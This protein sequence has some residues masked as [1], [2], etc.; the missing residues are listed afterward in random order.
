M[1]LLKNKRF[2]LFAAVAMV[3]TLPSFAQTFGEMTGHTSAST[4][5]GKVFTTYPFCS[6]TMARSDAGAERGIVF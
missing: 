1:H 4:G 6:T 2:L 5:A 3:Y